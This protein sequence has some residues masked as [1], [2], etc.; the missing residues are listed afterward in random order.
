MAIRV[1]DVEIPL[2][3]GRVARDT[4]RLQAASD[5]V[6]MQCIDARDMGAWYAMGAGDV[7]L[8][9][10]VGAL[11]GWERWFGIFFVTAL[12][13]GLM[14]LILVLARGRSLRAAPAP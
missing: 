6:P 5:G 14:A 12:I 4:V 3:P 9:A 2:V 13:G 8:M 7:K 1:R 11:V 10:A